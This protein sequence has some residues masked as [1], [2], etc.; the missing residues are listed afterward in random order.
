MTKTPATHTEITMSLS[1]DKLEERLQNL[2]KKQTT[3]FQKVPQN[4]LP[5]F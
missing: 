1:S 2:I 3:I 4:A 5:I